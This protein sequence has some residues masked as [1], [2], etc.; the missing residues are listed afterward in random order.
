MAI[1]QPPPCRICRCH[2]LL[3]EGTTHTCVCGH[4]TT[5]HVCEAGPPLLL[6]KT[7]DDGCIFT[8]VSAQATVSVFFLTNLFQTDAHPHAC[9]LCAHCHHA[10]FFHEPSISILHSASML[11]NS[12]NA[13]SGSHTA[14]ITPIHQM[15]PPWA[16][17][18][19]Q[20]PP[21][22]PPL[23]MSTNDRQVQAYKR[24]QAPMTRLAP[25]APCGIAANP[26]ASTS[27]SAPPSHQITVLCMSHSQHTHNYV[28]IVHPE[29]VS[30]SS[31]LR[32]PLIFF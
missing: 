18:P 27:A 8:A 22:Q 25:A 9:S 2:S 21:W 28:V 20:P 6:P 3:L 13:L 10:Y 19:W 23:A 5:D 24:H 4:S 26:F 16:F 15:T 32:K 1:V 12:S 7:C 30:C 11:P 31:T 29:P 14:F 17:A